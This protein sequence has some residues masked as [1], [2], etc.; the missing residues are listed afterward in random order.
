[1]IF[2]SCHAR[3]LEFNEV[4]YQ[5]I[6]NM[7]ENGTEI[8]LAIITL[9]G[10]AIAANFNAKTARMETELKSLKAEAKKNDGLIVKLRS[11]IKLLH[12]KLYEALKGKADSG[13]F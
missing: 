12:D 13:V 8:A 6:I 11:E 2:L 1:M 3:S 4:T 10:G 7:E 9:I 5:W